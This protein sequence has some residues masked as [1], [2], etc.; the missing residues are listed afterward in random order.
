MEAQTK[1][2]PIT[3][4]S[5]PEAPQRAGPPRAVLVVA[6][7]VLTF[8]AVFGGRLWWHTEHFADTDNA[9]ITG[10]VHPITARV[11]G[12]VTEM[13]MQDNQR[14]RTGDLL[15]KLDPADTLVQIE[16][17]K[18]QIAQSKAILART[19]LDAQ[20]FQRLFNSGQSAVTQQQLDASVSD[21]DAARASLAALQAQ[22]KDA[23]LQLAY[24][25]LHA[26]ADGRIGKRTVEVG[27][28]VQPGQQLA[29]V[30]ED[31]VWITANFK[32]TQLAKMK[33]GQQAIITI[34]AFPGREFKARV[35][36]FSPASGATFALLP[37]DN[38]TG[39]FT[40][41]VQ[42]LPVKLLFEPGEIRE[43]KGRLV[44][45]LSAL[46]SVELRN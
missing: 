30:V 44:P 10:R 38:A 31:D 26:P 21:R 27:Q 20:R 3:H 23:E 9:F 7:L 18:A 33:M 6:A 4:A 37:P 40:K 2:Q 32:E 34:D 41:I 36:S 43:L 39:N 17:V 1:V 14:V 13:S 5:A 42:R 35:D 29:A 15:L 24:T 16:R 12:V 28:R 22:L 8:A 25:E 45:G 19:E 11:A 46:V